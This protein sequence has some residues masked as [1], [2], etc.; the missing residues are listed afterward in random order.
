MST[1]CVVQTMGKDISLSPLRELDAE[2]PRHRE[3]KAG[4]SEREREIKRKR[5]CK[6][7]EW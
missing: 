7:S 1:G 5:K 6:G 3:R 4:E 2:N